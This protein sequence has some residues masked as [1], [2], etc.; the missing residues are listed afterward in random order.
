MTLLKN[1]NYIVAII[2]TILWSIGFFAH[3]AGDSV[4]FLFVGA[5]VLILFN[6][7]SEDHQNSSLES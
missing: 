4:H 2:L 1:I 6:V 5:L 7:I 3:L